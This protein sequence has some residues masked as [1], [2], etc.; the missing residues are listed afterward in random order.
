D[1]VHIHDDGFHKRQ[2]III[3][4]HTFD[5]HKAE[6]AGNAVFLQGFVAT[7]H[8]DVVVLHQV[9]HDHAQVEIHSLLHPEAQVQFDADHILG[10]Y[11]VNLIFH[12]VRLIHHVHV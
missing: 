6:V 11:D 5:H 12:A 3:G 10:I 2:L 1:A 9:F 8:I 4:H 7:A